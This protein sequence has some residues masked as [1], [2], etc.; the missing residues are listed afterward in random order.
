MKSFHIFY[1]PIYGQRI[2]SDG[3]TFLGLMFPAIWL[4][5]KRQYVSAMWIFFLSFAIGFFFNTF[6]E[7]TM[8]KYYT[9]EQSNIYEYLAFL[10]LFSIVVLHF[11]V[12]F[13]G[14]SWVLTNLS[15][16]GFEINE[17]IQ[18]HSKDAVLAKLEKV[19]QG[20]VQEQSFSSSD[21]LK[22]KDIPP[23]VTVCPS[24]GLKNKKEDHKCRYCGEPM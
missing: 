14:R 11:I 23:T 24:C 12:G 3:F 10:F 8:D 15:K 17:V 5:V 20:S 2:E 22:N 6:M 19:K 1:H 9:H 21:K 4:L 18:A 13:K 7:L 16:R